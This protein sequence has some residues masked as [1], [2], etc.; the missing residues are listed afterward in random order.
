MM[1]V[2]VVAKPNLFTNSTIEIKSNTHTLVNWV[3]DLLNRL[4]EQFENW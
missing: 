4:Y 3:C 2:V 1:V